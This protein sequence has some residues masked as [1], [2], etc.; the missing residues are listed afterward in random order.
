MLSPS[1]EQ[2]VAILEATPDLVVTFTTDGLVTWLNTAAQECL[3]VRAEAIPGLRITHL[4]PTAVVRQLFEEAIPAALG[5]GSWRGET[6][7]VDSGGHVTA[8]SQVIVAH[9]DASGNVAYLSTFLRDISA[10]RERE[11]LQHALLR[12]NAL[13]TSSH[14]FDAQLRLLASE[15]AATL[16]CDVAGIGLREEEGWWFDHLQ[17]SS[18]E[19]RGFRL[20]DA[21]APFA[22]MAANSREVVVVDDATRDPRANAVLTERFSERSLLAAPIVLKNE[23]LAVL[24]LSRQTVEPFTRAQ[25]DFVTRLAAMAALALGNARLVRSLRQELGLRHDLERE[26]ARQRDFLEQALRELESFSYSVSHDLRAPLRA[27]DGFA[28]LLVESSASRLDDVGLRYLQLIR[29]NAVHMGHLVDDLLSFARMGRQ[30][31]CEEAIEVEPMVRE[32][33]SG[34]T[35]DGSRRQLDLEVRAL[36]STRGDRAMLRRAFANLLENAIKYTL[37]REVAHVEVGCTRADAEDVYW[38]RDNGVGFDMRY[39]GQ[40]FKVFS[41]LHTEDQF[42]GTGVGL[43]VVAHVVSRHGGRVWAEAEIGRGATFYMAL[44]RLC[45]GGAVLTGE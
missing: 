4:H 29:R 2:C 9:R 31:M 45:P 41:R 22:V 32:I 24:V 6:A 7:I 40:L 13:L 15:C 34:L 26:L 42:E 38:I 16:R 44:P 35:E 36:G 3:G 5:E 17:V 30:E 28:A 8:V 18:R 23:V 27:I 19:I 33:W 37:P 14:E 10:A 12:I 43:A 11:A 20:P 25:V 39:A 1:A 21:D